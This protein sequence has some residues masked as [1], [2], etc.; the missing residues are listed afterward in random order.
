MFRS[1]IALLVACLFL[2]APDKT[3]AQVTKLDKSQ[4][5]AGLLTSQVQSKNKTIKLAQVKKA[6]KTNDTDLKVLLKDQNK[7]DANAGTVKIMTIRNIGGPFMVAAHNLST[8]LDEGDHFEKMRVIPIIARGKIQNLWDILYL[9]GIDLGF[10]Q[11]DILEYLKGDP[12]FESIK[13]RIRYINLMFPEEVHIVARKEIKRLQDLDG[14]TVSINAKGTGSSVV[15]TLLFR[16]LG[17]KAKLINEDTSRAVARMKKGEIFAHFNVLGKP[18][19]PVLRIKESDNLHLLPIPYTKEV[20]DVYLPS[21]FTHDD[22]PA[23]VEEGVEVP[24]I[25]AGNVLAVFNWP[26]DHFRYQKVKRFV[27]A[28]FSRFE[29][30]EQ[31]GFHPK[32]KEVNLAASVPG[33]KRFKPAQDWLDKNA[34]PVPVPSSANKLKTEFSK[35]LKENGSSTD[36]ASAKEMN[37]LFEKFLRWRTTRPVAQQ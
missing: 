16:R 17:I 24:T 36:L 25:A 9:R 29:E 32:W 15:G 20:Q 28:Y 13:D 5:K 19:R 6:P 33:W 22:Y 1:S 27:E 34:A 14:K 31:P 18:A 3:T 23:L 21:K 12:R 26:E 2:F 7:S 35:F 10:V 11:T 30:L 4:K 37:S 8:L